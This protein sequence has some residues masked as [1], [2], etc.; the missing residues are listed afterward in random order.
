MMRVLVVMDQLYGAG[1]TEAQV[2]RLLPALRRAGIEADMLFLRGSPLHRQS[3]LDFAWRELG[4]GRLLSLSGLRA[5]WA[6]R[7]EMRRLRARIV[8]SFFDDAMLVAA[9][10][11][12]CTP[13]VRFVATQRA[14]GSQ[15]ESLRQVWAGWALRRADRILVNSEPIKAAIVERYGSFDD[16]L[17]VIENLPPPRLDAVEVV[18]DVVRRAVDDLR[19]RN[20]QVAVVV[21]GLRPVKGVQDAIDALAAEPARSA[22]VGCVI[23]G[24]GPMRVELEARVASR[25]IAERVR[26]VGHVHN[27]PAALGVFDFAVLPSREE[28]SAN[29]GYEFMAAGLPVVATSVGGNGWLLAKSGAGLAVPPQDPL[30]MSRAIAAMAADAAQRRHWAERARTFSEQR[31]GEAEVVEEYARVLRQLADGVGP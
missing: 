3:E 9:L 24:D 13:A 14:L 26:F 11:R 21:A 20:A 29:A 2:I 22:G 1:G 17:Q 19:S 12:L 16:R 23:L 28:G 7:S 5:V 18:P 4:A 6:L 8:V 25:D 30:A 31:P 10:A 27:V 15:R